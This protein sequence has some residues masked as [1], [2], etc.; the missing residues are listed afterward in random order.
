MLAARAGPAG[1]APAPALGTASTR[2]RV[3]GGRSAHSLSTTLSV[4]ST[5]NPA[6]VTR[7]RPVAT[8]SSHSPSSPVTAVSS[9]ARST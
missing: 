2:T 9:L 7:H 6:P 8:A 3:A 1:S 5:P 4:A